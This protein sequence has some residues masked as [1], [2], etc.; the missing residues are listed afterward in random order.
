DLGRDVPIRTEDH[1]G[2]LVGENR[3][4]TVFLAD[5]DLHA[6]RAPSVL[7]DVEVERRNVDD[8]IPLA[9][10]VRQPA[11]A[12]HVERDL[13]GTSAVIFGR[14]LR[15]PAFARR[16]ASSFGAAGHVAI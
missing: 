16:S 3:R 6:E 10:I 9:E 1:G 8:Q 15:G 14:A 13:L 2:H 4:W 11:P 5:D 12:V 7:D